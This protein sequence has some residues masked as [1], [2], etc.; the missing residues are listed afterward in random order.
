MHPRLF[1]GLVF[2]EPMIQGEAPSEYNVALPTT[3]RQDLWPSRFV[4]EEQFRKNKLF[5]NWDPRVLD[6]Y[7]KYGLRDVPT[8]VYPF[9]G[10][11][12][13]GAVTLTTTK[14]QE[15]WS[16]LRSNFQPREP[17][18][19]SYYS[20][21]NHLIFP[22]MNPEREDKYLFHCPEAP[23]M[24]S[25]L[26]FLR[27]EVL[28]IFAEKSPMSTPKLQETKMSLT[29]TG[30]GGSG[31]SRRGKVQKV[32]LKNASHLVPCERVADCAAVTADWLGVRLRQYRVDEQRIREYRSEKSE[33]DM[34][35]VSKRWTS[36]ARKP[37][38]ALRDVKGKL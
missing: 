28:Y 13:P 26:P 36:E 5:R 37:M 20:S 19:G 12:K 23:L 34:L 21:V 35:V 15:A 7:L 22:D 38:T 27:P 32:V 8:A 30:I 24:E 6:A 11:I 18:P 1:T 2:I 3:L 25:L 10:S 29:G 31:G 14:H 4:A 16:Y 9:S 17:G 33:R